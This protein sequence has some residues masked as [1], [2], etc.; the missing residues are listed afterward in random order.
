[1]SRAR[2]LALSERAL[3]VL[4]LLLLYWPALTAWF[5]QDDF[6][7][8]N[9]HHDVHSARDLGRVLFAP[10]AHGNMRP[11]GEN[12]FWLVL[13]MIFGAQ[14]LPLH[15]AAFLTLS[16]SLLLLGSIARR[17]TGSH[18]AAFA[19]QVLWMVNIGLAPALGWSS[20]FNQVL[21]AFFFLLAF[22]FLLRYTESR[23]RAHWVA[24]W[25]A[26]LLGLGALEINVTYPA[27][28]CL[29]AL[30]FARK[31]IRKL[32]PMFAISALAVFL[33]FHFAPPAATGAYAPVVDGRL[34]S[35]MSTY[36][37]WAL[38]PMPV[39][40]MLA[41][42]AA[43][44]LLVVYG[45]RARQNAALLALGWFFIPLVPY[46]PLPEHK[47]DYYLAVPSIGIA[48]LGAVAIRAPWRMLTAACMLVYFGAS[49]PK[50]LTTARWEHKRGERMENLVL[51]VEEVRAAAPA[52]IVLL[53]G[54]DTDLFF[55]GLADLPFRSLRIPR[56]YL[57]P[58]VF[59]TIQAPRALLSKY[60][61]PAAIARREV[62]GGSALLY[63]FDGTML[64]RAAGAEIPAEDEPRFVNLAD[65]V[66]R[67]YLGEGWA[68]GPNGLRAMP[69]AASV[70]IG[71]PRA[72]TENLYVGVFDTQALALKVSANGVDV[73]VELVARNTDLS[74]YRAVLPPSAL[75]WST[76]RID[77]RADR[78]PV[79]FGYL[80]VR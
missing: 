44:V 36:W 79:L 22:Y 27:V 35:T 53:E 74:E 47:M 46:L 50:S 65:D 1:M 2:A 40:L 39:W 60:V 4:L 56:V 59:D 70:R 76:M 3:P 32:L 38:G 71:G 6:G 19:A 67:D 23:R 31:L 13:P 64:H 62:D 41:L 45:F 80:E 48:L 9:L 72:G 58:A 29:Y 63:R 10:K 54:V 15:L 73:P 78:S 5:F 49:I 7:W 55:S 75:Q 69:G 77:L 16:A 24:Q 68:A 12:A 21:S 11:L 26:F 28:A 51:G 8:L 61:L 42:T 43:T 37:V 18:L 30:L 20:I 52:K 57:A 66:F 33:H 25:A 14:P 17:L 34:L